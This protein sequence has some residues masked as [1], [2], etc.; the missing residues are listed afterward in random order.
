MPLSQF[1]PGTG[2]QLPAHN[3]P[4]NA[5]EILPQKHR[6]WGQAPTHGDSTACRGDATLPC[7]RAFPSPE[8]LR[9]P[10]QGRLAPALLPPA[11]EPHEQSWLEQPL[12]G[13]LWHLAD[14]I[15]SRL[16]LVRAHLQLQVPFIWFSFQLRYNEGMD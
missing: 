6:A 9:L 13:S 11:A 15:P 3:T 14:K 8:G 5:D 2:A 10:G 12:P 4:G 16:R 1:S 7:H